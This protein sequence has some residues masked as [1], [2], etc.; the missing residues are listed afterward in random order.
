M[1]EQTN[2]M[3]GHAEEGLKK[4]H[5][6]VSTVVF[7][8]FC[9]VAAGCFGIEEMIPECG[10]GLTVVML[11]VLPFVWALPFGLV[12]SEL[13]SVRPQEG[14]YYYVILAVVLVAAFSCAN[15]GFYGTVRA[16]YGL[17]VEGLA[18]KFLGKVTKSGNPRN[19]VLFTL[20][21]MW[22]VLLLGL[23]SQVA[24]LFTSLY[25]TLLSLSG[26]TG[27]LAWVGII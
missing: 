18:P 27:T 21:F 12:A 25:G 19:A 8:I 11:C 1:S 13:G 22:I 7:M 10:P 23:I 9:L 17:S 5:M 14:G 6:K 20:L 15:T 2:V 3:A 26:F 24:G 16:L 4:V